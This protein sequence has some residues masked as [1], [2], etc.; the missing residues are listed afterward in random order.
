MLT[1]DHKEKA[2]LEIEVV[3]LSKSRFDVGLI[4]EAR[5]HIAALID[6]LSAFLFVMN[7]RRDDTPMSYLS[8]IE[9]VGSLQEYRMV[10]LSTE[11]IEPEILLAS[12]KKLSE[13]LIHGKLR[14]LLELS[15]KDIGESVDDIQSM[16]L[17][18]DQFEMFDAL[19]IHTDGD[20]ASAE[21]QA[22]NNHLFEMFERIIKKQ[23]DF[24]AVMVGK[25]LRKRFGSLLEGHEAMMNDLLGTLRNADNFAQ[26]I[27]PVYDYAQEKLESNQRMLDQSAKDIAALRS[28][29]EQLR[30]DQ[31]QSV[32]TMLRTQV[33]MNSA[34]IKIGLDPVFDGLF[35]VVTDIKQ[36]RV[37]SGLEPANDDMFIA[38]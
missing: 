36:G 8:L 5:D 19:M 2:E 7:D 27:K 38:E 24:T 10:L 4:H 28:D 23:T 37:D 22:A 31:V 30:Q 34:L 12:S 9:L 3:D 20:T 25:A 15:G 33:S 18:V 29:Y 32:A 26:T 11:E 21:H 16:I 6:E 17:S 1:G 35:K 14:M 13:T